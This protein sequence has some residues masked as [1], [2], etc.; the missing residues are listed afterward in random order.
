M[1]QGG[2]Q[3]VVGVEAL[4]EQQP[5]ADQGSEQPVV[6]RTVFEGGQSVQGAGRQQLDKE[7]EQLGGAGA[8]RR[9]GL[10]GVFF[11]YAYTS[12]CIRYMLYCTL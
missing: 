3:A 10:T 2:V 9:I 12:I 1:G 11:E 8:G 5:K 6:E 7:P 4:V